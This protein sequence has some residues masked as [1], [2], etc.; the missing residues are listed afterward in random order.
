[1][2]CH[3]G[4]RHTLHSSLESCSSSLLSLV[5]DSNDKLTHLPI[6]VLTIVRTGIG[7]TPPP[8]SPLHLHAPLY[9]AMLPKRAYVSHFCIILGADGHGVALRYSTVQYSR[10][11][12][13]GGSLF[14]TPSVL[15][16]R[17]GRPCSW[18]KAN[19]F[20]YVEAPGLS[21]AVAADDVR[22]NVD[23]LTPPSLGILLDAFPTGLA[24]R[25]AETRSRC[26][27]GG[28]RPWLQLPRVLP[29]EP[30]KDKPSHEICNHRRLGSTISPYSHLQRALA[31]RLVYLVVSVSLSHTDYLS[32]CKNGS[33]VPRLTIS[34]DQLLFLR[35]DNV[36]IVAPFGQGKWPP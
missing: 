21:G 34:D 17:Q 16:K 19:L 23:G 27:C 5:K 30:S 7:R 13:T 36:T 14:P 6:L 26:R 24:K 11:H 18:H 20:N 28:G 2:V 32:L 15:A 3:Y 33:F 29:A 4:C 12:A 25:C 9:H 10:R 1:M 31:V 35:R 8:R 22:R